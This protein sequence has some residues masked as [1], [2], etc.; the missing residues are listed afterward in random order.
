MHSIATCYQVSVEGKVRQTLRV[1][2]Q[3]K[4]GVCLSKHVAL[5]GPCFSEISNMHSATFHTAA[6]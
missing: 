6:I 5:A 4:S 3:Y 1:A 2:L